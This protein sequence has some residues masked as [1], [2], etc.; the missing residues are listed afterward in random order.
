MSGLY[1]VYEKYREEYY[2][3]NNCSNKQ[4]LYF[5]DIFEYFLK[6]RKLTL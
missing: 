6:H 4:E 2:K 1:I 3:D 5:S